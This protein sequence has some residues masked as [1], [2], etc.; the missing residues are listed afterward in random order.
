[1]KKSTA[2]F[3]ICLLTG[4]HNLSANH[5]PFISLSIQEGIQ[6]AAREQKLLLVHFSASWCMLCQWM[7][8]NTFSDPTVQKYLQQYYLPIEVD[9]DLPGGYA[10]KEHHQVSTLPTLLLFT[11]TGDLLERIEG[12]KYPSALLIYLEKNNLPENKWARSS[13]LDKEPDPT[14]TAQLHFAHLNKPN[15]TPEQNQ[16]T[17]PSHPSIR[18]P[19]LPMPPA[20]TQP[21]SNRP[22]SP[23][24]QLDPKEYGVEIAVFNEYASVIRYVRNLEQRFEQKIYIVMEYSPEEKNYHVVMGAYP[25]RREA[26]Q[27]RDH[28]LSFQIRGFVTALAFAK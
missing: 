5:S 19:D 9:V 8:K 15:F 13:Y 25:N 28:L 22:D 4:V 27:L 26:Y 10:D 18:T 3:V 2:F 6:R 17:T 11:A 12:I 23:V 14:Q 21:T 7:E 1:M 24:V 20:H 16:P